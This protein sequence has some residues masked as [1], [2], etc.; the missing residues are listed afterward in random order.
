MRSNTLIPSKGWA[1]DV[2]F[3]NDTDC[4]DLLISSLCFPIVGA[5]PQ[6][7]AGDFDMNIGGPG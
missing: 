6:T 1:L 3:G 5:G 2:P 7:S 4:N